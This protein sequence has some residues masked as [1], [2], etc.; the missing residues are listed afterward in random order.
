MWLNV[1]FYL[2]INVFNI[3]GADCVVFLKCRSNTDPLGPLE[4]V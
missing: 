1:V 3:Y 2:H 4:T